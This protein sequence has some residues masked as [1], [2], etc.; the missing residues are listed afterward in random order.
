MPAPRKPLFD[1]LPQIDG[2]DFTPEV[3][4][5]EADPNDLS[6]PFDMEGFTLT[7]EEVDADLRGPTRM[8]GIELPPGAAGVQD[9][10]EGFNTA[11]GD[12]LGAVQ[13]LNPG[14]KGVTLGVNA[15]NELY[16]FMTGEGFL[17]K[18]YDPEELI[19]K[20]FKKVGFVGDHA[21]VSELMSDIG[22]ETFQQML[23]GAA[24]IAGA[25]PMAAVTGEAT[26]P[27]IIRQIGEF[28][29]RNPG[30]TMVSNIGSGAGAEIGQ[31]TGGPLGEIVG[32]LLGA[33]AGATQ[34]GPGIGKAVGAA[35]GGGLGALGGLVSPLGPAGTLVGAGAGLTTGWKWGGNIAEKILRTGLDI[36]KAALLGRNLPQEATAWAREAVKAEEASLNEEMV[37]V[38]NNLAGDGADPQMAAEALR[39][40][41]GS[42]Y[43]KGQA[44]ASEL[45]AAVDQNQTVGFAN[46]QS[47]VKAVKDTNPLTAPE[48]LPHD[49]IAKI[50]GLGKR[51]KAPL[52][53]YGGRGAGP[54]APVTLKDLR[55][56]QMLISAKLRNDPTLPDTTRKY[57]SDLH[58]GIDSDIL[59]ANPGDSNLQVAREYTRWLHD[60]LS[61][62]PLGKFTGAEANA[63]QK[64]ISGDLEAARALIAQSE[65]GMAIAQVAQ[66]LDMP[67]LEVE[68]AAF[69]KQHMAENYADKGAEAT[70]RIMQSPSVRRF[71]EN[72]PRQAAEFNANASLL[73]AALADQKALSASAF[74]AFSG[75]D[76]QSAIRGIFSG[77]QKVERVREII[78][79][80]P[81]SKRND[82]DEALT[83]SSGLM[84]N[85]DAIRG[86]KDGVLAEFY[87]IAGGSPKRMA[88]LLAVKDTRGM[89]AE[90][91]GP[92]DMK[93]LERMVK[94]GSKLE[95]TGK[96][97]GSR[98]MLGTLFRYI[99]A[100]VAS[101][102]GAKTIQ[103]TGTGATIAQNAIEALTS[104]APAR[105]LF[106]KAIS[107]PKWERL[108]YS[109]VP[110]TLRELQ[111]TQELVKGIIGTVRAVRTDPRQEDRR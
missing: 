78:H 84:G 3:P 1:D 17:D 14:T 21:P 95:A 9:L 56:I 13:S 48:L 79:G 88:D 110:E 41:V 62:G 83:A 64:S 25:G 35:V 54:A 26:V 57:L 92:E 20:Y 96:L 107:D 58:D 93:R 99:G 30:M 82:L 71:M 101:A 10:F 16:G 22:K 23:L 4:N 15:A 69:M 67:A 91:L 46:A 51:A 6:L 49:I 103:Q 31:E 39:R 19:A 90:V 109:R 106:T 45:W 60:R 63:Y 5:P 43:T 86:F 77:G 29:K 52:P 24:M 7:P 65:S 33:G 111:A 50:E 108:L 75:T 44:R 98:T 12:A 8:A 37:R 70:A 80:V 53:Q 76:P 11:L 104:A 74:K 97:A 94:A 72:F 68:A 40:T 38:Y 28:T 42:A 100:G 81:I 34:V 32:S 89:M 61:R 27:M 36:E 2:W 105:D 85:L 102:M 59:Q 55:G 66:R 47:A 73:S 18:P 87:G